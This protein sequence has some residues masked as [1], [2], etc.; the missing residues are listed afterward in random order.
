MFIHLDFLIKIKQI[1]NLPENSILVTADVV[2]LYSSISHELGLKALEEALEK[3][4]SKQVSTDDLIKL[5]KFVLQNNYFKFNGEVKQ[6]T[7]G[8]AIG[9]NPATP[10]ACIFIDQVESEF[11]K[12]QQHQPL[13]WFRYIDDIFFIWTLG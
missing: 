11:L 9:T 12:T 6:Q 8:T 5:T 10:Y 1:E 4:E 13:V 7:S 2:G 3:R